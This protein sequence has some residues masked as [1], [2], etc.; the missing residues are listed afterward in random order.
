MSRAGQDSYAVKY[1]LNWETL[2]VVA[3]CAAF[4][5]VVVI[6]PVP[7]GLRVQTLGFFG[8]GGLYLAA[9][10]VSWGT[11]IRVD[12]SGV[13]V[14]QSRRP[15]SS[16]TVYPWEDIDRL[17]IWQ[18]E[19]G[20]RLGIR[21]RDGTV[22]ST[23]A[24]EAG[25]RLDEDLV[26]RAVVRYAPAVCVVDVS[27]N[28]VLHCQSGD[29]NCQPRPATSELMGT[30]EW[31][32]TIDD[33]DDYDYDF[34]YTDEHARFLGALRGLAASWPADPRWTDAE[35]P[36]SEGRILAQLGVI[37]EERHRI[38]LEIGACYDGSSVHCDRIFGGEWLPEVP[39]SWAVTATG[40]PEELA[41]VA[42]GWFLAF[43]E[44]PVS[45]EEWTRFGKIVASRWSFA[46][47]GE[48]LSGH[49]G[50]RLGLSG[51]QPWTSRPAQLTRYVRG[52]GDAPGPQDE[53]QPG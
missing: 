19:S 53:D 27:G 2:S 44:R 4:C 31:F 46:D 42:A 36:D 32:A 28:R 22:T 33:S 6:F 21:C 24:G 30:G 37:D 11:A 3:S 50:M 39:T 49:T 51:F 40:A 41:G 17:L 25:L 14:R 23:A 1:R 8:L 7:R 20:K 38:F 34:Q 45:Y 5:A 43:L 10:R 47:T 16:E 12:Q 48:A 13:T 18:Y 52:A 29:L 15:R 26:V 9:V 35:W